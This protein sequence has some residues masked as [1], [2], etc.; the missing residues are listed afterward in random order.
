M[1]NKLLVGMSSILVAGCLVA[2]PLSASAQVVKASEPVKKEVVQAEKIIVKG[3]QEPLKVGKYKV[4]V[5][6]LKKYVDEMS[7][8]GQ[9]MDCTGIIE[10][11]KDE[12]NKNKNK[13][14]LSINLRR[15]DWM[16]NRKVMID[17]KE[18]EHTSTILK[19]YEEKN[20]VGKN[21]TDHTIRFEIPTVDA[22]ISL[23]MNVIPMGNAA[24]EFRIDVQDDITKLETKK[25]VK[26]EKADKKNVKEDKEK[27]VKKVSKINQ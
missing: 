7:M 8:A 25:M 17:G 16:E 18:V 3:E 14:Y 20:E 15:S 22:K 5:Y 10:V 27:D 21:K 23:G 9:Y 2:A 12:K 19:T 6:A 4:T 24:V 11:I 26:I 13:E 1:K